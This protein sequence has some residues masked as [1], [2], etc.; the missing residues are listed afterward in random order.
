[1]IL[2]EYDLIRIF[3]ALRGPPFGMGLRSWFSVVKVLRHGN[4][5]HGKKLQTSTD[6]ISHA[7]T[8]IK[9]LGVDPETNEPHRSHAVARLL[10]AIITLCRGGK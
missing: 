6:H 8:H 10:L 3:E 7:M 2:A 4:K 9:L 1:M 5:K